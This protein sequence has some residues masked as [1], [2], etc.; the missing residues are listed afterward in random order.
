[1]FSVFGAI[2]VILASVGL[3]GVMSFSVNQRTRNSGSAWRWA[4]IIPAFSR[5]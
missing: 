4:R 3:Y 2:A 5:W 1:M